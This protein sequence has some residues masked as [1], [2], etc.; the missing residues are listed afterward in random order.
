MDY[1]FSKKWTQNIKLTA[2]SETT[3][4]PLMVGEAPEDGP[5]LQAQPSITLFI[6][7]LEMCEIAS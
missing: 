1:P 3:L 5:L 6:I 7:Q 2:F 4:L